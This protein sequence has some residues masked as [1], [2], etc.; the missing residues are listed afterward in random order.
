MRSTA[1][2][3]N[4]AGSIATASN[5]KN[6]TPTC[7]S[8]RASRNCND[9]AITSVP[10]EEQAPTTPRIAL[11]RSGETAR[12]A[13]VIASEDAV[14]DSAM[15]TRPPDTA[16]AAAPPADSMTSMPTT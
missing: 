16:N 7:Q 15:P 14:Q 1:P 12:A 6:T 11:R 2:A 10:T 8:Q 13:A 5:R 3:R 4:A 9:G